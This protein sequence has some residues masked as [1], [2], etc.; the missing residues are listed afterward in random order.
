MAAVSSKPLS[1]KDARVED[2]DQDVF[3]GED[4]FETSEAGRELP[5]N[6]AKKLKMPSETEV[7]AHDKTHIPF[8]SWCTWRHVV[9]AY[10]TGHDLRDED[11]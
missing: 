3:D 6:L 5:M 8:R 4:V 2:Q 9:L 1:P 7:E 11:C 10:P